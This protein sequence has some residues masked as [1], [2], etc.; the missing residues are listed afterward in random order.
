MGSL[1]VHSGAPG[2][3]PKLLNFFPVLHKKW[4][5]KSNPKT[6][7]SRHFLFWPLKVRRIGPEIFK[8]AQNGYFHVWPNTELLATLDGSQLVENDLWESWDDSWENLRN[9]N[10]SFEIEKVERKKFQIFLKKN[11]K[12]SIFKRKKNQIFDVHKITLGWTLVFELA[13]WAY[14]RILSGFAFT[15]R[16][17]WLKVNFLIAL[18][19]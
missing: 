5:I 17:I 2:P 15:R 12:K 13:T 16:Q 3:L 11:R 14:K 10:L 1:G 4:E 7:C 9:K 8:I 19:S 18:F 6:L